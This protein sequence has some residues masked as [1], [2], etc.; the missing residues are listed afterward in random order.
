MRWSLINIDEKRPEEPKL[1]VGRSV[2]VQGWKWVYIEEVSED[3]C[4]FWG[5]DQDGDG[6]EY[7]IGQVDHFYDY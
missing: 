1:I 3:G 6:Q 5:V 4:S 2:I 7:T